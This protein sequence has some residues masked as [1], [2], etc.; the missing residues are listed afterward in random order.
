M[1]GEKDF[2]TNCILRNL[3]FGEYDAMQK[4]N[5]ILAEKLPGYMSIIPK[6]KKR[7]RRL[8]GNGKR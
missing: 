8:R 2:Q 4:N 3:A 6:V 7:T 5:E 1:E